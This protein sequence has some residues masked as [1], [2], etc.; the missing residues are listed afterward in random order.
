MIQSFPWSMESISWQLAQNDF[1]PVSLTA[2]CAA[3]PSAKRSGRL[4]CWYEGC[5]ILE[6]QHMVAIE[7]APAG[8]GPA[9][10]I[11]IFYALTSYYV[12]LTSLEASLT[13]FL[14]ATNKSATYNLLLSENRISDLST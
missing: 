3:S 1:R 4:E 14:R 6:N 2:A 7:R 8:A 13:P 5:T 9:R 11:P 10:P 12:N